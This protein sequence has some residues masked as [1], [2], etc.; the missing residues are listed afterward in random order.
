MAMYHGHWSKLNIDSDDFHISFTWG[1]RKSSKHLSLK[2]LLFQMLVLHCKFQIKRMI[3][4]V[5]S[6]IPCCLKRRSSFSNQDEKFSQSNFIKDGRCTGFQKHPGFK[7]SILV[8]MEY[9]KGHQLHIRLNNPIKYMQLF[10][11]V[12]IKPC[13]QGLRAQCYVTR[14]WKCHPSWL[15]WICCTVSGHLSS[16]LC[17]SQHT[18]TRHFYCLSIATA[19]YA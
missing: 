5:Q 18:F 4:P 2:P 19:N 7:L 13:T 8:L 6:Q 16:H 15:T 1:Q 12:D 17:P 14:L 10:L 3:H 11:E 9:S